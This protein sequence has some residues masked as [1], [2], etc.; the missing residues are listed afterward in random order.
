M[1]WFTILW[2][3]ALTG[4]FQL[5]WQLTG[6]FS[7][8]FLLTWLGSIQLISGTWLDWY[9]FRFNWY[10]GPQLV[11]EWLEHQ[12]P[13]LKAPISDRSTRPMGWLVPVEVQFLRQWVSAYTLGAAVSINLFR[14]TLAVAQRVT[15]LMV[16]FCVTCTKA[17]ETV[18]DGKHRP[19]F[20]AFTNKRCQQKLPVYG[21]WGA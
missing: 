11:A 4:L 7:F 15:A 5:V 16:E 20:S 12:T 2:Y 3:L 6:M 13:V 17:S 9:P 21:L 8:P 1:L 14:S 10:M 19:S 18:D